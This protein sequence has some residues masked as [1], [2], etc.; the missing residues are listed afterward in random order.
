MSLEWMG[1]AAA[2]CT[3]SSFIPQAI[4]TIKT[5][6]TRAISLGMYIIF[7]LG[8]MFWFGY[9]LVLNDTAIILANAATGVFS[10]T[11]LYHKV[12]NDVLRRP[13]PLPV[14]ADHAEPGRP[15]DPADPAP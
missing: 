12:R 14:A 3:A 11:V 10:L 15:A 9:G 8:I 13:Q 5:G 2:F 6:D 1:Y 4:H 7:N